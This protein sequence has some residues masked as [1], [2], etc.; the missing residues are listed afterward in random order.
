MYKSF[1]NSNSVLGEL[2]FPKRLIVSHPKRWLRC[3]KTMNSTKEAKCR[4]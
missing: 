1:K 3:K 4:I 2:V